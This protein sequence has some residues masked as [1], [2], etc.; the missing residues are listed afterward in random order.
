MRSLRLMFLAALL[1]SIM[2]LSSG[3]ASCGPASTCEPLY[4]DLTICVTTTM[5]LS[6]FYGCAAIMEVWGPDGFYEYKEVEMYM[7][8][9]MI[10]VRNV[11]IGRYIVTV[12]YSG[13]V[14]TKCAIVCGTGEAQW[15]AK[16]MSSLKDVL[17]TKQG[18]DA[19]TPAYT[20]DYSCAPNGACFAEPCPCCVCFKMPDDCLKYDP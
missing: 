16:C 2:V 4:G 18:R 10:L 20:E 11:P 1:A 9:Q 12:S 15:R 8:F 7:G 17:N 13:M 3:C 6:Y 14:T 19:W 5:P